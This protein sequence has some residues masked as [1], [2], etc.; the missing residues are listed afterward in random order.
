MNFSA[1][2]WIHGGCFDLD[3]KKE[4]MAALAGQMNE[5]DFW[6]D[7]NVAVESGQRLESLR[8]E[9]KIWETLRADLEE[10]AGL[11][12]LAKE[13][14]ETDDGPLAV[15]LSARLTD[16]QARFGQLE[17]A[18]LL[19][20]P[21]DEHNAILS[22][23]AGTG[24]VDAQDWA[25]MLL[26]MYLRFAEKQDWSAAVIDK[27]A[28]QEAGLKSAV[29]RVA[30]RLAYGWLQSEA[31][32]HRLVRI[33]PFDAEAMRHTSFALVEVI[34]ELP[35]AKNIQLKEEELQ[36]DV[37]RSSGPGGQ[38]VNTTDSAVR[39]KH[40]PTGLV[41][42]CQ[43]E[44]SQH[45]NKE[46]AFNILRAKLAQREEAERRAKTDHLRGQVQKAEWGK[47]IR[48]YV[49]EPYQLIKDHRTGW[50]SPNVHAVLDGDLK[51]AMEAF[52][53]RGV[54]DEKK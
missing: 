29:V 15:D 5:P 17:S 54:A 7:R 22:L 8:S 49:L 30:G 20:G 27:T 40:L 43:N 50:E 24:G 18:V 45:Q 16:W 44:R 52:L 10:I 41:I 42:I 25:A 34:P 38:S 39:V 33:S 19:A 13:E 12:A 14:R 53:R 1:S 28:G 6:R 48:S 2:S 47:Q 11:A 37:F 4:T 31:G 23:H 21:Y 26:R 32:V 36:I 9:A 3:R 51:P 46:T 35:A